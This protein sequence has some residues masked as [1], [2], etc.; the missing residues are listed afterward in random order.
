[1]FLLD[2]DL[3]SSDVRGHLGSDWAE[4]I[5]SVLTFDFQDKLTR[6]RWRNRSI[7]IMMIE[8]DGSFAAEVSL[9]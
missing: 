9:M 8:I 6:H 3:F 5:N 1:M 7:I 2:A 4:S